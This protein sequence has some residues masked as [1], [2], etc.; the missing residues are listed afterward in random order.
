MNDLIHYDDPNCICAAGGMGRR[1]GCP[2]H[3]PSA[4]RGGG[5][6]ATTEDAT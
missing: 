3:D 5:Q 6:D 4:R 2:V 1:A